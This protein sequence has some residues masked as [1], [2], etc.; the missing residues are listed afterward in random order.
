MTFYAGP[1]QGALA[2][3]ESPA[4]LLNVME[5]AQLEDD[6]VG[7]KIAV[8]APVAGLTRTQ[9]RSMIV[10]AR[11]AG[12]TVSW[13]EPR[14]GGLAVARSLRAL[15]GELTGVRR[16]VVGDPY[17]G[18]IQAIISVTKL[19]EVTIV[20]DG[21]ATLE[22]A[23]QWLAGEQFSR[24]H[25]V[26]TS[27]QR[28][29]ITAVARNQVAGTVRR[30]LSPHSGFRLRLFTCMPVD[31]PG[32]R[33]I[34]NDFSWVRARHPVPQ[35][36][37][38]ADLVGTSLVESGVVKADCYLGGVETLITRYDADR[39][40][41]HRKEA[42]WKLDLIERMGIEV[43][44][45]ALPLEIVARRGPVGRTIV[46]FPST[47]V[48]TLPMVL[49]GSKARV[50]VCEIASEWYQPETMVRADDFLG[51]VTA[52]AQSSYGVGTVAS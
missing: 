28:R 37:P 19:S 22:F 13:H 2:L 3:V 31:L 7:L 47:V 51:R 46:S 48:H 33:V 52:S 39:Y 45:A 23:R 15:A 41:A 6:L 27:N 20:D 40:F 12:H 4:Q 50:V 32:V 14:L 5:L 38:G 11:E 42:D 43:A 8:L 17:S 9:L 44:R 36:K 34:R 30:R 21:T 1:G 26:T 29:Q 24:W 10:L 25:R 18:V 49:A 16:L 35:L